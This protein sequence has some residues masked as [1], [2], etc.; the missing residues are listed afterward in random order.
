M[1]KALKLY[2]LLFCLLSDFVLFA[3]DG[4]PGTDA[5]DGPMGADDPPPTPI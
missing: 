5:S 1:K 2:L 3:Q 4:L